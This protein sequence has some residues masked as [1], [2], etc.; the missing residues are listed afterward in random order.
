MAD[1]VILDDTPLKG[2][3]ALDVEMDNGEEIVIVE[4]VVGGDDSALPD[5]VEEAAARRTTF[6]E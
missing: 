2:T 6:L 3:P 4:E 5:A 1:A